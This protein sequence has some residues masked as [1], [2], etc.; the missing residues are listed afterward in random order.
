MASEVEISW[1]GSEHILILH[2]PDESEWRIDIDNEGNIS[3][4]KL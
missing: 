1:N 2:S 4:V 3:A